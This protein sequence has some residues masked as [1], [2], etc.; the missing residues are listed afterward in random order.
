[1]TEPTSA[2][3]QRGQ[4]IAIAF[5]ALAGLLSCYLVLKFMP[6][7]STPCKPTDTSAAWRYAYDGEIERCLAIYGHPQSYSAQLEKCVANAAAR[8]QEARKG[9]Q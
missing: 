1:M 2:I 6:A 4:L 9:C 5:I 8:T 7:D 3:L